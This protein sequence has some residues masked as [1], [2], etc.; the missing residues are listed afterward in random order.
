MRVLSH[1]PG[2]PEQEVLGCRTVGEL[3]VRL[4]INPETVL[5]LSRGRLLTR[6]E[7]LREDDE[8]EIRPVV[9]GGDTNAVHPL[10]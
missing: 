7:T 8:V 4:H 1:L 9:S 2:V 10:R 3:L 6:D 5:I